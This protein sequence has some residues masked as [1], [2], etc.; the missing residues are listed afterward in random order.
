MSGTI[1]K[2][3]IRSRQDIGQ[4]VGRV[5]LVL[6]IPVLSFLILVIRN[7]ITYYC[8]IGTGGRQ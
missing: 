3:G 1:D 6:P 7:P 4:P 5:V 2:T 8:V